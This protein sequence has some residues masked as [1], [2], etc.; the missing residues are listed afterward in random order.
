MVCILPYKWR[1]DFSQILRTLISLD[2]I[3]LV[4]GLKSIFYSCDE[5]KS[6][7]RWRTIQSVPHLAQHYGWEDWKRGAYTEFLSLSSLDTTSKRGCIW[8]EHWAGVP[9]E[10]FW[11]KQFS[12]SKFKHVFQNYFSRKDEFAQSKTLCFKIKEWKKPQLWIFGKN[13][14]L[15][16]SNTKS[17]LPLFSTHKD[18]LFFLFKAETKE[19][20][21]DHFHDRS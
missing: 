21:K 3:E 7:S 20:I 6:Q 14:L 11:A 1:Q 2:P 10:N 17:S 8:S 4:I 13:D 15:P 19:R 9:A 16:K 12:M 5:A 18:L